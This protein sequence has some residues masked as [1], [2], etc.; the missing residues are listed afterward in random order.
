[1]NIDHMIKMAN[2]IGDFFRGA[3]AAQASQDVA[4]HLKR[5]WDPRMRKQMLEYLDERQGA[6][7]SDIALNAVMQLKAESLKSAATKP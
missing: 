1:M 4:R 5:Y 3:T 6:G 2:E 7:L